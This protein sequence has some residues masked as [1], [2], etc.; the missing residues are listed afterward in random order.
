M[1]LANLWRSARFVVNKE[2]DETPRSMEILK[3]GSGLAPRFRWTGWWL[4]PFVLVV[5]LHGKTVTTLVVDLHK[6]NFN[7]FAFFHYVLNA[8]HA[9][10][11][12][13]GNMNESVLPRNKFHK[14]SEVLN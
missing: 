7:L 5:F 14:G 1:S 9:V 4:W 13:F 11:A 2:R 8:V 12:K 3:I 10:R 6:T